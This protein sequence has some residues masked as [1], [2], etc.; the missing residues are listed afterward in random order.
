MV[1]ARQQV[2][3]LLRRG[4]KAAHRAVTALGPAGWRLAERLAYRP[5]EVVIVVLLA[6][7][8]FGG[9]AVER[10]RARQ[11]ALAEQLEAE[12]R[13]MTSVAPVQRS[14]QPRPRSGATRCEEPATTVDRPAWVARSLARP[15]LDLKRVTPDELARVARIS[16]RLAARIVAA[17]DALVEHDSWM[18][19]PVLDDIRAGDTPRT[20]VTHESDPPAATVPEE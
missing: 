18:A 8:L 9:L 2:G 4:A 19:G 6:G 15:R 3:R 11:P 17:R 1:H 16:W 20:P 13:R 14:R 7:G 10:W 12:P 5:R